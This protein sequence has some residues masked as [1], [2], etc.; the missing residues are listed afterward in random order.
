MRLVDAALE[1][2]RRALGD[3]ALLWRGVDRDASDIDVV[4]LGGATQRLAQLDSA[5]RRDGGRWLGVVGGWQVDV[6]QE[7]EWSPHYPS[8]AGVIERAGRDEHGLRVASAED[9]LL[10]LAAEALE[11]RPALKIAGKAAPLLV[12]PGVRERLHEVA[13]AEGA[14]ALPAVIS[15][16]EQLARR[17]RR[18]RLPYLAALPALRSRRGRAA[19]ARRLRSR[20][21]AARPKRSRRPPYLVALSGMDGSGKSGAARAAV[22]ALRAAGL[23][24]DV[25][26]WRLAEETETL[27][28]IARPVKR[29]LRVRGTVA[30]PA[31]AMAPDAGAGSAPGD[32]AASRKK[33][34]VAWPWT[35]LV[36]ALSVRSFRAAAGARREGTSVVCD[37]WLIDALV[38]VE[39]RYGRHRAATRLMEAGF[40]RADLTILLDLDPQTAAER[41]PDD[42]LPQVLAA[43]A[44]LYAAQRTRRGVHVVDARQPLEA[45]HAEVRRL[46]ARLADGAGR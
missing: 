35:L 20:L 33:R 41:K 38:D 6:I 22:E 2:I 11:G 42:Q 46:V 32:P 10:V 44:P 1:E 21:A 40:P 5:G 9:R 14:A 19:I 12:E 30:D 26:W 23:D 13:A 37:R 31:A 34:L 17:A 39:L 3:D 25:A 7:H 15:S 27:D 4:L 16:P 8:L 18:G 45:V 36:V 43:M 29:L 24:A 28:R